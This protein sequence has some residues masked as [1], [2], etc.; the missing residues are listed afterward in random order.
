M[1]VEENDGR[2]DKKKQLC[3]FSSKE[4]A[5]KKSYKEDMC[6]NCIYLCMNV[7]IGIGECRPCAH[8]ISNDRLTIKWLLLLSAHPVSVCH[9]VRLC[10]V[11]CHA[12]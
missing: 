3:T 4:A 7:T 6:V 1:E 5:K 12:K 8:Q 2:K 9:V 11:P 10:C